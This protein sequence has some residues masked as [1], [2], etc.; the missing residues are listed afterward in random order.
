[1]REL[2]LIETGC[3]TGLLLLSLV[4]PMMLS[5]HLPRDARHRKSC[6]QTVWTGQ[7]ILAIAG[8]AMLASAAASPYAAGLGATGYIA[9][10][11]ILRTQLRPHMVKP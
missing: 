3:F 1:M 5:F 8:L 2:T 4:L 10:A 7:T 9:C 11:F 6:L